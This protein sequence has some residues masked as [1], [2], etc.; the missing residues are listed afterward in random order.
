MCPS[1]ASP[2]S[3]TFFRDQSEQFSRPR[4]TEP[5]FIPDTH[6][7]YVKCRAGVKQVRRV[8]P[9]TDPLFWTTPRRYRK[10][11][12]LRRDGQGEPREMTD[13]RSVT[14]RITLTVAILPKSKFAK[15]YLQST[16]SCDLSS[17]GYQ[18]TGK[19]KFRYIICE[20]ASKT[21]NRILKNHI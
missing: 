1:I 6:F 4:N 16:T 14:S 11:M 10:E 15:S 20:S 12:F 3:K 7:L 5:Q 17:I 2:P 8:R 21:A 13:D 9:N 19:L 18:I